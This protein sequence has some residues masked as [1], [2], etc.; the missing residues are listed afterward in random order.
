MNFKML[1]GTIYNWKPWYF[2]FSPTKRLMDDDT[3]ISNVVRLEYLDIT[4]S[5][6]RILVCPTAS[7]S[8]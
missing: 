6:K 3:L 2:G 4:K 5:S 7:W 1:Y 8:E